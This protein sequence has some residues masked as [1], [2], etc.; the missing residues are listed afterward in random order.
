MK[1]LKGGD[2]VPRMLEWSPGTPSFQQCSY[3]LSSESIRAA[4]SPTGGPK[5][6]PGAGGWPIAGLPRCF[7]AK[8]MAGIQ[9]HMP[10]GL[11]FGEWKTPVSKKRIMGKP[12]TELIEELIL[13]QGKPMHLTDILAIGTE[14]GLQLNGKRP[15]QIQLRSTL[16]NCKRLY[17]IGGNKW[18]VTGVALPSTSSNNGHVEIMTF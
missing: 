15:K 11:F 18:W 2:A 5:T 10:S 13:E 17:N 7:R 12:K 3:P 9:A 14:R 16:S 4:I 6:R 1:R 8:A